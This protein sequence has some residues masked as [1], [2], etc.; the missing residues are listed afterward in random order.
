MLTPLPI[1]ILT[2]SAHQL[3]LFPFHLQS[4][5]N[6][7]NFVVNNIVSPSSYCLSRKMQLLS[8]HYYSKKIAFQG[9]LKCIDHVIMPSIH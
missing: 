4:K 2:L 1:S 6:I 8:L 5:A 7:K 3:Q 9:T